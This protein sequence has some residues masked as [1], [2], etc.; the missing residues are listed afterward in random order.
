MPDNDDALNRLTQALVILLQPEL[1]KICEGC[2]SIVT[3]KTVI[4]PNCHSYRF[5]DDIEDI[6]VHTERI[7]RQEQRSVT[8]NDL[9]D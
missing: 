6:I 7:S 9:F 8:E 4:C 1:Y 2:D 5:N 3:A